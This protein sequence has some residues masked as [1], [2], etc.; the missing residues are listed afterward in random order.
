MKVIDRREFTHTIAAED[1]SW[2]SGLL[3]PA[4]QHSFRG[5]GQWPDGTFPLFLVGRL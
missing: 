2:K 3:R 4:M 1:G 5:E